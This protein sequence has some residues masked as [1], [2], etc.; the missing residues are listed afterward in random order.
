M[1]SRFSIGHGFGA[2]RNETGLASGSGGAAP[3]ASRTAAPLANSIANAPD[4]PLVTRGGEPVE[5]RTTAGSPPATT[6]RDGSPARLPTRPHAVPPSRPPPP[7][8]NA[9]SALSP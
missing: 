4:A 3:G 2:D 1:L 8:R 5:A 6:S 9:P 7:T